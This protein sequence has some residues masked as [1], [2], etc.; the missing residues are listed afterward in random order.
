MDQGGS[1]E[2]GSSTS[3]RAHLCSR[4]PTSL[5]SR[6]RLIKNW[7]WGDDFFISYHWD[8]GGTYAVALAQRLRDLHYAVF[9]DRAEYAMGDDWREVGEVKLRN[10]Q[11]LILIATRS[12]VT[13]SL[14]VEREVEIFTSKG[15]QVIPITFAGQLEGIDRQHHKVLQRITE[16][17]LHISEELDSLEQGPTASAIETLK[18]THGVL[19]RRNIRAILLLIPVT[20]VLAAAAYALVSRHNAVTARYLAENRAQDAFDAA[21]RATRQEQE[22]I[23]AKNEALVRQL[24]AQSERVR[25]E[26]VGQLDLS[27]LLAIEAVKRSLASGQRSLDAELA[28]RRSAALLPADNRGEERTGS[29]NERLPQPLDAC[30]LVAQSTLATAG[31]VAIDRHRLAIS[32]D[33]AW[34]AS[35]VRNGVEVEVWDIEQRQPAFAPIQI[36][37]E[38]LW[39]QFHPHDPQ[40]MITAVSESSSERA[41]LVWDLRSQRQVARLAEP[42]EIRGH[43]GPFEAVTFHPNGKWLLTARRGKLRVWRVSD[44]KELSW[45]ENYDNSAYDNRLAAFSASGRYLAIADAEGAVQLW[46]ATASDVQQ[47]KRHRRRDKAPPLQFGHARRVRGM[48]FSQDGRFLATY[49]DG[50]S[51]AYVWDLQ[52]GNLHR[53][54]AHAS[55]ISSLAISADARLLSTATEN[56]LVRIWDMN[57]GLE[58]TRAVVATASQVALA[59]DP[60]ADY[61]IA[62]SVRGPT[63]RIAAKGSVDGRVISDR[64]AD[65]ITDVASTTGSQLVLSNGAGA[66][67]WH[68]SATQPRR[69]EA[70]D[71][72]TGPL[73]VASNG[74]FFAATVG[75]A[76]HVWRADDLERTAVLTLPDVDWEEGKRILRTEVYDRQAG[77]D[78]D[79]FQTRDQR[80]RVIAVSPRGRYVVTTLIGEPIQVWDVLSNN[81]AA[82]LLEVER[83]DPERR[84]FAPALRDSA[85][86]QFS[87]DERRLLGAHNRQVQLWDLPRG[88]TLFRAAIGDDLYMQ[89]HPT[90]SLVA[91]GPPAEGGGDAIHVYRSSDGAPTWK[92]PL[93]ERLSSLSL[94]PGG[95]FLIIRTRDTIKLWDFTRHKF[96]GTWHSELAWNGYFAMDARDRLLA[97]TRSKREVVVVEPS[98]AGV[99]ARFSLS[100]DTRC[101]A[102][103]ARGEQ[104]AAA[105]KQDTIHVWNLASQREQTRLENVRNVQRLH[106]LPDGKRL[107]SSGNDTRLWL[108]SP[109]GLIAEAC[110]C[111][112]R[113]RLDSETEWPRYLGDEP[114]RVTC[115]PIEPARRQGEP[116]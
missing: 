70:P 66:E 111:L 24:A 69:L 112:S 82:P 40:V 59:F 44:W 6:F 101:L 14:P 39:I 46:D 114:Y 45:L 90:G 26:Q 1:R 99:R 75:G 56:S 11:H 113:D 54:F 102:F 51:Q 18:H 106:F 57:S 16:S 76:V 31:D 37:E 95:R 47:W 58:R 12:A 100:G 35:S 74:A 43:S 21:G 25:Q 89:L 30:Y 36:D 83:E 7:L 63:R 94:S 41:I 62:S 79:L 68:E 64:S 77:A 105:T 85:R 49:C 53:S 72:Q 8:S 15:R 42:E 22:A 61:V 97:Y 115:V 88:E 20:L 108:I 10:S 116:R 55:P 13:E 67:I 73:A 98:A 87:D 50:D 110:R 78:L 60:T 2:D 71:P 3:P 32:P 33:G 17:H 96:A 93:E 81:P 19:R 52:Q 27:V 48:V 65:R 84:P 107:A 104:L 80:G 4:L 109:E 91:I 5:I 34:L 29:A 9:L 23:R 38:V 92:L 103:D 86:F 28:L